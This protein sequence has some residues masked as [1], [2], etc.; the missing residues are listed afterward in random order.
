[1]PPLPQYQTAVQIKEYGG[2]E[3]LQVNND[4]PIPKPGDDEVLVKNTFAGVNYVD[5]VN[6]F[7]SYS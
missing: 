5:T 2:S 4:V 6:T 1:M 3:V 7:L